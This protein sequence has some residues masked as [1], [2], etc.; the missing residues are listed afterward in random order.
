MGAN[1]KQLKMIFYA[2]IGM[3]LIAVAL[4]IVLVNVIAGII[5]AAALLAGEYVVYRVLFRS[6]AAAG[7]PK[8][9]QAP[10]ED[11]KEKRS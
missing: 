4:I 7:G 2:C 1:Q 10:I 6:G 5:V 9:E 8:E 11:Q 3:D